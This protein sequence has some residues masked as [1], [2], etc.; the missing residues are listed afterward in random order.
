VD[1]GYFRVLGPL[2]CAVGGRP[3]VLAGRRQRAVL[4]TLLLAQGRPVPLDRL[5]DAVWEEPPDTADKQVRNIVSSLRAPVGR[6]GGTVTLVD[7]G[8]SLDLGGARLDLDDFD[9][10]VRT[11]RTHAAGTGTPGDREHAVTAFRAGLALWRGS[12]LAGV[13]SPA[14]RNRVIGLDQRRTAVFEECVTLEL[15]LGRHRAVVG[16]LFHWADE[17]PQRESLVALLI[18]ALVASGARDLALKVYDQTQCVLADE[19]GVEPGEDLQALRRALTAGPLP[20]P[21]RAG[22]AT[23]PVPRA[24][25]GR[26]TT[27]PSTLP[28]DSTAF[29]GRTAELD[30]LRRIGRAA[31]VS[32]GAATV[33]A[34]DG[35]P[36]V[37]KTAVAVRAARALVPAY[38]DGQVFLDLQAH[39][40]GL[41]PL[42]PAEVVR[43]LLTALGT[44]E[45]A[46]PANFTDRLSLW[47]TELLSR[48]LL[49]VLDNVV[50]STQIA[51]LL[52]SG[53]GSLTLVTSRR[54]LTG[55]HMALPVPLELPSTDEAR[56][57][58][59]RAVGDRR[60][61]REYRAVD[62][63]VR[64]CGRL[65]L[66]LRIAAARLRHRPAWAV[67]E[68][69][70]RLADPACCLDELR[71]DD[72]SVAASMASSVQGLGPAGQR[73]MRLL[74]TQ[75]GAFD[76]K[77]VAGAAGLPGAQVGRMLEDLVDL[78]LV[79][80]LGPASYCLH[81]LLRAYV[82][83]LPRTRL[84]SADRGSDERAA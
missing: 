7:A 1:I 56:E 41:R 30:R 68:L 18:R 32:G 39:T 22:V 36:G 29:V 4:A 54:R 69:A 81:P 76:A 49:L 67:A 71:T 58:F 46:I 6:V 73:L 21:A 53:P 75:E 47:H 64:H 13:G 80:P 51:A 14:L 55:L 74:G 42:D 19:L 10:H 12:A 59:V 37:G 38:P 9:A 72:H 83:R 63:V 5:V 84:P 79:E 60:P 25:A 50:D 8:Y 48:R 2:D 31:S 52:P 24:P 20:S 77:T 23:M 28:P 35:M 44:P 65:P 27:T 45:A 17:Q 16:E 82:A 34:I 26:P 78:H 43:S 61:L 11:A 62:D 33:V 15:A 3:I 40:C 66:A 57:L 70:A